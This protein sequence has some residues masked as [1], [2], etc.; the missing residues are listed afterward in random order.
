MRRGFAGALVGALVAGSISLAAAPAQ[1]QSEA[2][3]VLGEPPQETLVSTGSPIQIYA[4]RIPGYAAAVATWGSAYVDCVVAAVMVD[5]NCIRREGPTLPLV[6]VDPRT[7][8]VTIHNENLSGDLYG[9]LFT[10]VG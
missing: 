9:C 8:T 6:E 2:G 3:C 10:D 7:L 5:V 4:G 1:A